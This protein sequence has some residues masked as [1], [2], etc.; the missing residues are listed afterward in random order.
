MDSIS[1]SRVSSTKKISFAAV[2]VGV[3]AIA[4]AC[5]TF[6]FHT[7]SAAKALPLSQNIQPVSLQ[8]QQLAACV[9]RCSLSDPVVLQQLNTQAALFTEQ[10]GRG[11][12]NP[13]ELAA[14]ID[15]S[16]P[17]DT[18]LQRKKVLGAGFFR[19]VSLFQSAAGNVAVKSTRPIPA[20]SSLTHLSSWIDEAKREFEIGLA[21]DHPNVVKIHHFTIKHDGDELRAFLIA[22][23]V[24]GKTLDTMGVLP[25]HVQLDV[26]RQLGSTFADLKDVGVVAGDL[27]GNNVM[28]SSEGTL[29][30]I[31]LEFWKYEPNPLILE[32]SAA[33]WADLAEHLV[34]NR[35]KAWM[36]PILTTSTT[37]STSTSWLKRLKSSSS[38]SSSL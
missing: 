31:D 37:S 5:A 20:N 30:F 34:S 15:P 35:R 24:D 22:D 26:L 33:D 9:E 10:M 17:I 29:K 18:F 6:R 16:I 3:V 11:V 13:G 23:Y 27:H 7:F 32:K 2:G 4:T 19:E 14:F 36:S 25:P 12:L 38:T 21:I 1:D 28:L 8:W